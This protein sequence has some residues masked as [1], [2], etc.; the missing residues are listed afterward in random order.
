MKKFFYSIVLLFLISL[1]TSAQTK[2]TVNVSNYVFTPKDLTI[3][4]GDTVM[5]KWVEGTHTTTSDSTTGANSWDA[6]ITS[7]SPTFSKVLTSPG[8]YA[9]YCIYHGAPGGVGMAG[10]ITVND[11][12]PVELTSFKAFLNENAVIL[13]W[14]TATETN[15]YGFEVERATTGSLNNTG[16]NW[17]KIGFIKGG[18]N[19][20]VIK[21]YE[22]AD[23]NVPA[24]GS[25]L[26]RL[27]QLDFDGTFKYSDFAEVQIN[28]PAK[29]ELSQ[30]FPNPF[31]P[32]TSIN[33]TL[34]FEADISLKIY[35]TIGEEFS[36][37]SSGKYSS[38]IHSVE[39]DAGK[40]ESGIYFYKLEA[41]DV[42]GKIYSSVKKMLLLK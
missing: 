8:I 37:I 30:N 7:D 23:K 2:Y 15:N 6:P 33:F 40:Y 31:N 14:Q 1:I 19:S 38:G 3:S 26:Y 12:I 5:W 20:T 34:P 13:K 18:N 22:F 10:T 21:N 4:L 32:V 35:N 16:I 9:Y 24:S 27:K 25:F 17:N 42:N 28:T 41:K 11:V 36:L 39:F 29:F